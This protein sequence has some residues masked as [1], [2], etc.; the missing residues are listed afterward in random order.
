MILATSFE[1]PGTEFDV[2]T[3][4]KRMLDLVYIAVIL[5]FFVLAFWYIRF[6]EKV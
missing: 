6:C 2:I 5:I 4:R 1:A 3:R